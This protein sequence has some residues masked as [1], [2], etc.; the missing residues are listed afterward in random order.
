MK[1]ACM[2]SHYLHD[3]DTT[4]GNAI[5]ACSHWLASYI[6]WLVKAIYS[7]RYASRGIAIAIRFPVHACSYTVTASSTYYIASL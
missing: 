6:I 3:C 1:S 2:E 7:Y 4:Q 5:H